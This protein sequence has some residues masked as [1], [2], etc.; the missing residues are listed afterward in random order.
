MKIQMIGV[1][2]PPAHPPLPLWPQLRMSDGA[3]IDENVRSM[4]FSASGPGAR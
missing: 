4:T 2:A 1:A 3:A